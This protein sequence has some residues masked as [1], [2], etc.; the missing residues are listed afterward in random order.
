VAAWARFPSCTR[1]SSI[2]L[3]VFTTFFSF[4]HGLVGCFYFGAIVNNT[5]INI[6]VQRSEFLPSI[7]LAIY[8]GVEKLVILYLTF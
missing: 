1:L 5:V 7:T 3:C 6:S 2:P 8:P 4:T